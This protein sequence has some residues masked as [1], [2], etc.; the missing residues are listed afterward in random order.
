MISKTIEISASLIE[1]VKIKIIKKKKGRYLIMTTITRAQDF[2]IV[3]VQPMVG[4]VAPRQAKNT[5]Q[6]N[7]MILT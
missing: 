2:H 1:S 7:S 3:D 6:S 5:L 4:L